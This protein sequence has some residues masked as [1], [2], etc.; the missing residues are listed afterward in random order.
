[1]PK[2][3]LECLED[4]VFHLHRAFREHHRTLWDQR[5]H[6]HL[7]G[8]RGRQGRLCREDLWHREHR[9]RQQ[10]REDREHHAVHRGR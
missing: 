5:R 9:E 1:M 3:N 10:L 2:L 6:E 8:R 4:L 7:V